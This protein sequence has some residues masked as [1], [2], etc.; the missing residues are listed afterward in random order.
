MMNTAPL[1]PFAL[2]ASLLAGLVTTAGV[3]TVRNFGDWGRH[4]AVYFAC[5]AAGILIAVSF[6]H[7]MPKS[8]TLSG[9]S[10][11]FMLTGYLLMHFF[12]RFLTTQVC[13]KPAT[14]DYAIGLVAMLGIGFHSFVDGVMYSVTFTVSFFTGVVSA[15]GMVLHEFPE[16]IITYVL[17]LRGGIGERRALRLALLSAAA[18]TPL[19]TLLSYNWIN[20]IGTSLLGDLMACSAGA[21]FYVGATHLLPMAEREPRRFSLIVLGAG[22]TTALGITMSAH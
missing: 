5:F 19:G 8:I 17:L 18:T 2:W 14:A 12:N 15:T 3:L 21:L 11:M 4:N 22:V 16:G 7:L 10:P 13:D 6:L 9:Q 20:R 1:I